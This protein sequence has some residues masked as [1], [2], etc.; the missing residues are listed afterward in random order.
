MKT[1]IGNAK[2]TKIKLLEKVKNFF[3]AIFMR[4]STPGVFPSR[5]LMFPHIPTF[6]TGIPK[7]EKGDIVIE[8]II[9]MKN[10]STILFAKTYEGS[11]VG[12][13]PPEDNHR[14]DCLHYAT[15][16]F[17]NHKSAEQIVEKFL[18]ANNIKVKGED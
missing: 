1:R 7:L 10:G 8:N 18:A 6:D 13:D 3:R 5:G 2:P 12:F 15:Y 4:K 14:G 17:C 11:F 9:T 16:G